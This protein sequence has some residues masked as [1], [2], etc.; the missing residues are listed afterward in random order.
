MTEKEKVLY[1]IECLVNDC[2]AFV[3]VLESGTYDE[4]W[5]VTDINNWEAMIDS[6]ERIRKY[7]EK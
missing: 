3:D 6:L 1:D 7:V 2:Q 5:Q 4:P